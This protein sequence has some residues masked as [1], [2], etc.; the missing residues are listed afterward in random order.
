MPRPVSATDLDVCDVLSDAEICSKSWRP[1]Y[2][3]W[4]FFMERR[5][6]PNGYGARRRWCGIYWE[7]CL[8]TFESGWSRARHFR[9]KKD[10]RRFT[11]G[12]W[13]QF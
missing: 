12:T 11:N 1:C 9:G 7:S 3:W 4:A 10:F 13:R 5:E 8:Q 6:A 2:F